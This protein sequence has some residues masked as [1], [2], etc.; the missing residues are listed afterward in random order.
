MGTDPICSTCGSDFACFG[1]P[2]TVAGDDWFTCSQRCAVCAGPLDDA[3]SVM[4]H[5]GL[6]AFIHLQCCPT[7][8][9]AEPWDLVLGG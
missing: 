7:P 1:D 2:P 9:E 6:A 8:E 5:P 4:E 3:T